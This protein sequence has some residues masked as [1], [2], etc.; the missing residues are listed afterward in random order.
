[1]LSGLKVAAQRLLNDA[2]WLAH[3]VLVDNPTHNPAGDFSLE[4]G[5]VAANS[6]EKLTFGGLAAYR[7][8]MF[9]ALKPGEKKA[10]GP[11]LKTQVKAGRVS[12]E[13]YHGSWTDVGTRERLAHVNQ[14]VARRQ[15]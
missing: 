6:N 13:H 9:S 2:K 4:N 12:G 1:M 15:T 5:I 10:L 14:P 11:M 8:D 3:L 7:A